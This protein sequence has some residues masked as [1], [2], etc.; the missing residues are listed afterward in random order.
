MADGAR[1]TRLDRHPGA[2]EAR[3]AAHAIGVN[4]D[5]AEQRVTGWIRSP[6]SRLGSTKTDRSGRARS[7][8]LGMGDFLDQRRSAL[9]AAPAIST[10]I[11]TR[12]S[13]IHLF[14]LGETIVEAPVVL[15]TSDAVAIV[16]RRRVPVAGVIVVVK[17]R[18]QR[19]HLRHVGETIV[20]LSW[21]DKLRVA[22]HSELKCSQQRLMLR[23]GRMGCD[24]FAKDRLFDL[25]DHLIDRLHGRAC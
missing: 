14:S 12:R 19:S 18:N 23:D 4:S 8:M 15:R 6:T 5:R 17:S 9:A 1:P 13:I 20:L 2:V 24:T 21:L 3:F 11:A 10:L 7:A 25:R 22:A 16:S